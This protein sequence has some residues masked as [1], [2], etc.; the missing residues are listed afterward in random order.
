MGVQLAHDSENPYHGNE[1]PER[2][3]WF[4]SRRVKLGFLPGASAKRMP[5][6]ICREPTGEESLES[7]LDIP[8]KGV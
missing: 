1:K 5:S 8:V 6:P 2:P 3:G 4:R 7:R